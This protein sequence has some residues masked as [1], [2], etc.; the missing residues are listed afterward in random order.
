MGEEENIDIEK[1]EKEKNWSHYG[2]LLKF[3][4]LDHPEFQ[5]PSWNAPPIHKQILAR[6]WQSHNVL[7]DRA[8]TRG[9]TILELLAAAILF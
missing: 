8:L 6:S 4:V 5:V 1:K 7:V 2:L 9:P 3:N